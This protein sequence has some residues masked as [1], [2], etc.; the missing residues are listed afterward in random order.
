MIEG[1]ETLLAL[2]KHGSMVS[3]ATALRLSQSTISKRIAAL[4][5]SYGYK[6][7]EKSGRNVRLSDQALHLL[8]K[9]EPL[10]RQLR[11]AIEVQAPQKKQYVSIGVSESILSS[12]GAKK[13]LAAVSGAELEAI[14]H[15]HRSPL[16]VEHVESGRYDV[17]IC[18]GK[19]TVGR[20]L[21]SEKLANEEMIL[22]GKAKLLSQS[23]NLKSL[24]GIEKNSATWKSIRKSCERR[25]LRPVEEIESFFAVAQLAMSGRGVGL[26]PCG[27][28]DALKI[29]EKSRQS[30]E[31]KLFR[32]IQL[33]YKK[34]KLD[35]AAFELL[36]QQI[37]ALLL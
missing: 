8:E 7:I 15:C 26:I 34:S 13:I 22:V 18:A 24:V 10:L 27:V 36:L 35:S 28:A 16:V 19:P 20:S 32:P 21:I 2:R 17:G 23:P 11:E 29:A 1:L 25:R 4:E 3:V 31:P 14:F 9:V 33:I 6:L 37:R 30:L 5:Q 12:W